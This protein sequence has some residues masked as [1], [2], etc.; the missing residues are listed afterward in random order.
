MAAV[1][2]RRARRYAFP[3]QKIEFHGHET[4]CPEKVYILSFLVVFL[5]PSIHVLPSLLFLKFQWVD[6]MAPEAIFML[7]YELLEV[8]QCFNLKGSY[9]DRKCKAS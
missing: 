6:T 4:L 3:Y 1:G 7:R 5:I 8:Q 9:H 2:K